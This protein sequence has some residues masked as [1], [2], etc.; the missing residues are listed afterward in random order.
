MYWTRCRTFVVASVL[1]LSAYGLV[2]GEMPQVETGTW[3]A[4]GGLGSVRAGAASALLEDGTLLVTGGAGP[5]DAL[6][7]AEILESSGT[8][9]PAP[10]MNVARFD[11]AAVALD[12]GRVLVTGGRNGEGAVGGAEIYS[13]GE[14]SLANGLS[15]ARWGHT[16]TLLADGRVLIAGGENAAGVLASVEVFDPNTDAFYVAG[17]LS[18]PRKGHAAARLA[19]GRV[20]IAG[21]FD[22][23]A[24]LSSIDV[25]DPETDSISPL[26][27]SLGTARAG[28]S[29]TTLLDGKVLFFG[30]NDG[31]NDLSTS[32]IFN[33]AVGTIAAGPSAS[34]A[35]R[36]HSAFL[37]P[38][39]N[40]VLIV[41]GAIADGA[42]ASAELYLPWLNQFWSTA[43]PAA[44]RYRATGSALSKESYGNATPGLLVIAG[45][46]GQASAAVYGFATI[47]VDKDDYSPGETVYVSGSGWQPGDVTFEVREVPA[48][49]PPVSFTL[50]ADDRGVIPSQA[51][52]AVDGFD[53]GVRFFLTAH[54]AAS[55]SQVTFTDGNAVSTSGTVVSSAS[56]NP[57][58][59][60]TITCSSGCT[61][62]A[63]STSSN[64]GGSYVFN[65]TTTKLSFASNG[66]IDLKLTASKP[67]FVSQDLTL[68]GVKNGDT[69][70]AANFTLVPSI[71]A[72]SVTVFGATG[73]YSGNTSLSATLT[74]GGSGLSGKSLAFTLN[75]T[76]VGTAT[77]NASGTATLNN[78]SLSGIDAATYTGALAATFGGDSAFAASTGTA[79][80]TVSPLSVNL[81]GTRTYDG[82][83]TAAASILSV[84]NGVASDAVTVTSGN[85]TL[86]GK[87][88]GTRTIT[89]AAGLT[90]GGASAANYTL[91]GA[92]GSVTITPRAVTLTGTRAYDGTTDAAANTLTVSNAPTGDTVNV[93]SGVASLASKDVG[94]RSIT[95]IGTL[96]LGN[97]EAGNYT[98][99]GATGTVAIT[100]R[101]ITVA[102]D[103]QTKTYGDADP[104]LTYKVTTGSLAAGDAF[105]GALSRLVGGNVGTY[106]IEQGTLAVSANYTITFVG[107]NL[108]ITAR[109]ITVTADAQSKVY[110][111]ADPTLTYKVTS[112][113]LVPE[114]TFSGA[115]SRAAGAN[116]G[117]YAI[118]QGTLAL[119]TNYD[120]TFVGANLTITV[121]A[122]AVT[123]D[124]QHKVY[125][126]PDPAL[127]YT[128]TTGSLVTGDAFIG[129]LSRAAGTNVGTY[130]IEQGTLVLSDNYALS[131]IG[132]NLTIT[133]RPITVTADA[134]TKIYGY[135]DP[136]LTYQLTTGSLVS[137]DSFT[138]TLTR[139]SGE[140]VGTYAV[141]QGT[142][143]L[144]S[145]YSLT[146]VPANFT[147]TP[148]AITITADGKAK[149]YGTLDPP[150]T[151]QVTSGTLVGADTFAGGL[152]RAV[153][154]N[155][156]AYAIQ[157]GSLALSANYA[158]TFVGAELTITR[159][160][161]T[162]T[163]DDKQK[164]YDGSPFTAFTSTITG[165][166]NGDSPAVVAGTVTYGSPATTAVNP[167]P[168]DIVPVISGLSALN[169][170]FTQVKGTLT[171]IYGTCSPTL[172]AGGVVL[173]PINADGS[174][175]YQRK[176]GS[177][178]PV[179]FRVCGASGQSISNPAA[180]FAG[181]G[182]SLTMLSAVRGTV[183]IA[184]E[185]A[186]ID[187]PDV[188]FRW[189]PSG[190]QWIFNM[191][192]S[193]LESGSTYSFSINLA[194]G[195]IQF[196]VGV[197]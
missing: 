11:H 129:A 95:N 74:S 7:T 96:V 139:A 4:I 138:G 156:G 195:H 180:V 143:A 154:Q 26:G 115:I 167:G 40:A 49:E 94:A 135:G 127:T 190:Q 97:N 192:T 169:Y 28:L 131:Y 20:L 110:G 112:G 164:V 89:G 58:S 111:D 125:G 15:D 32:E 105:S 166:V 56:G 140:N 22:G 178:I 189:D 116:V 36:D 41:G 194:Y 2:R 170:A 162:V 147:I 126:D 62:P 91:T 93:A 25:F 1:A 133:L 77:T 148:R 10:S 151:Y 144:N 134:K 73:T 21:G 50:T 183:T 188:A 184:T 6:A 150:L 114:D 145:N 152:T 83:A 171:I 113:S 76:S 14:W 155:V 70:T 130:A 78:V 172:G 52:F 8:F 51:L 157:Q 197:K 59:G 34:A 137:G 38:N 18:S 100:L 122:I 86:S 16:A 81:T 153:G 101:P 186:I 181:T 47:S 69:I 117:T 45:G 88:T 13:D 165:F 24:T 141:Q 23:D 12:D 104:S 103:P 3:H 67:G 109:P 177:T 43:A 63:P 98:L 160:T 54:D 193:N 163:A 158:L 108:T 64:A 31:S 176:G 65:N 118:G 99:I 191:S 142:V 196:R 123:A 29:A 42:S 60:A 173:P 175:V 9:S 161:L 53:L 27:V 179:K 159:A 80:L 55:Q 39:N 68:S 57:I 75:G 84:T 132:A 120:L 30:G 17:T 61:L 168:Y 87:D 5:D 136:A 149:V 102:A 82:T 182:G 187:I 44:P 72:S 33:P 85:A 90:L 119:S 174:S 46:E 71:A 185:A 37:L 121:R 124:G 106:A 66:P 79:T 35:R 92:S 107:A 128:V 48:I 19:D 146:Y